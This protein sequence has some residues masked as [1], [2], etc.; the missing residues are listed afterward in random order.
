MCKLLDQL[1]YS[2]L[3]DMYGT[4]NNTVRTSQVSKELRSFQEVVLAQ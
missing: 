1:L 4:N 3:I 2:N